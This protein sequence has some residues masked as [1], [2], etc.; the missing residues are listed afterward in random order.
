VRGSKLCVEALFAFVVLK[1]MVQSLVMAAAAFLAIF[2]D[3]KVMPLLPELRAYVEARTAEFDQ[4]S[5]ERRRQLEELSQLV[6]R[7]IDAGQPVRLT[8]ICTHNSR[9]SHLAQIWAKAAADY[10]GLSRVETFSGGTEATAFNPRAVNALKRAGFAIAA[11][12]SESQNNPRYQ[13]RY[14]DAVAALV[15]FSK[16]YSDAANPKSEFCAVMTC[17]EA[18]RACPLVAGARHRV[19]LL[20]DD[21]KVADGTAEEIERYDERCRQIAREMLYLFRQATIEAS[22]HEASTQ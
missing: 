10:Y 2:A 16:V 3:S 8:F 18:D 15:C 11:T 17:T 19:S 22:A 1:T 13:V 7:R 20:Y 14:S 5:A 21:P 12:E 4:I 9:R 6:R